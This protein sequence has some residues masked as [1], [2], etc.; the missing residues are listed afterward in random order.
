MRFNTIEITNFR[1]Y[2][3]IHF[4]FP[5]AKACDL[6][7]IQASNGVGKTNLLNAINWCIYGD[8]PHLSENISD[9]GN[10]K[11][12]QLPIYNLVAMDEAKSAGEKTIAVT[13]MIN[14][15]D[16]NG[17][18]VIKRTSNINV[19]TGQQ[20]GKDDFEIH[21]YPHVGDMIIHIGA[22]ADSVVEAHMPKKIR[23]YFYFDGELLLN[24]LTNA[25][26]KTSKIRDS[27]YE[28]SGVNFI[29]KAS[30]HLNEFKKE[31]LTK[32]S[33]LSPDLEAKADAMKKAQDAVAAKKQEIL[34]LSTQIE[35][36][37]QAIAEADKILEG[38]EKARD[39][40]VKYNANKQL[41]EQNKSLLKDAKEDLVKFVRDYFPKLMLYKV[42]NATLDYIVERE[43][44]SSVKTEVSIGSIKE[45]LEKHECQLCSQQIPHNIEDHLR[46]IITTLENNASLQ[47]LIGIKSDIKRSLDIKNYKADKEKI[48][49]RIRSLESYIGELIDENDKLWRDIE[50]VGDIEDIEKAASDKKEFEELLETNIEKRGSYKDKLEE[51]KKTA[52][53]KENEYKQALDADKKCG[54]IRKKFNF[55]DRAHTIVENVKKETVDD[56]ITK[57]QDETMNIFEEL[58][59]K[60]DT[61]G[62]VELDESFRLQLYHKRTNQSCLYSCSATEKELLALS[63]T[64]ALQN[65]SG[66]DNLLFIDTPVGRVSDINRENFAKVL[67]DVSQYKQIILAFT[68]S[69]YSDEI[70]SVLNKDVISSFSLLSYEDDITVKEG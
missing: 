68:P 70:S 40:N 29:N 50:K 25:K 7:I 48:F 59:W 55:V 62:R 66:Y 26:S 61:Y 12:E 47:T 1:Q 57:M 54:A 51:L 56:I 20:S 27:I 15:E 44:S 9:D 42:N 32:I 28:I 39:A 10:H 35:I 45:S 24:Y 60:K 22:D 36:A 11:N 33:A 16:I 38:N 6:H 21:E 30:I 41:I 52:T 19:N 49:E 58:M 14:A 37:N 67:L 18:Y 3:K 13:V 64:I 2:K 69:E 23:E 17:E 63:F 34:D 4:D 65:I 53:E 8:E 43:K 5:K 31:Y 46:E